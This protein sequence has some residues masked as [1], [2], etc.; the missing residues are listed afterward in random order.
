MDR[1]VTTGAFLVVNGAYLNTAGLG[2]VGH[3][4]VIELV[5]YTTRKAQCYGCACHLFAG[6]VGID[7]SATGHIVSALDGTARRSF[8]ALH[9][10]SGQEDAFA[11]GAGNGISVCFGFPCAFFEQFFDLSLGRQTP[12]IAPKSLGR[13][14]FGVRNLVS[15]FDVF[16]G[17]GIVPL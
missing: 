16:A 2:A 17:Q 8:V 12:T 6:F 5:A 7:I 9:S 1:L 4:R 3:L 11:V 14:I 13:V 10:A 15:Y